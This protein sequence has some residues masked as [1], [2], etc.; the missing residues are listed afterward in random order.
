MHFSKDGNQ[1]RIIGWMA[2]L[3]TSSWNKMVFDS[4]EKYSGSGVQAVFIHAFIL[5]Q[6]GDNSFS[7]VPVPSQERTGSHS[8]CRGFPGHASRR[9]MP[10]DEIVCVRICRAGH[11][12]GF[13][14]NGPG[15]SQKTGMKLYEDH[16][17]VNFG[18]IVRDVEGEF[19]KRCGHCWAM[20]LIT[21]PWWSQCFFHDPA[22][23][24]KRPGLFTSSLLFDVQQLVSGHYISNLRGWIKAARLDTVHTLGT[25]SGSISLQSEF[26]ISIISPLLWRSFLIEPFMLNDKWI[27]IFVDAAFYFQAHSSLLFTILSIKFIAAGE[28]CM[29]LVWWWRKIESHDFGA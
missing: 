19:S 2:I 21:L 26:T 7:L 25:P 29:R 9:L 16:L 4:F 27:F 15:S 13:Y 18:S 11:V 22:P 6:R 12:A 23:D 17:D 10:G 5:F 3:M 1:W 14:W 28:T 24:V 20:S 8:C